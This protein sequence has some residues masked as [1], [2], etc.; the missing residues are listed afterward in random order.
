MSTMDKVMSSLTNGNVA[1]S[2]T[3]RALFGPADVGAG[4]STREVNP[5]PALRTRPDLA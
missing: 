5:D 2:A 1:S 4:G 3:L